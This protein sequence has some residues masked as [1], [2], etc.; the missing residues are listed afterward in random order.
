MSVVKLT[1]WL[2]TLALSPMLSRGRP[3]GDVVVHVGPVERFRG[4]INVIKIAITVINQG[5]A[6]VFLETGR[7]QPWEFHAVSIEQRTGPH[8]WIVVGPMG[9][10]PSDSLLELKP[11]QSISCVVVLGNS[12]RL[13]LVRGKPIPIRGIHRAVVRYFASEGDWRDFRAAVQRAIHT[14]TKLPPGPPESISEPFEIPAAP[15][16]Q[17]GTPAGAPP[18]SRAD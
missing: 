1:C 2:A 11:A 18:N 4:S 16:R 9:D 14:R 15:P 10:T 7:L 6:G 17:R 3:T 8:S 5:S 12:S 13:H